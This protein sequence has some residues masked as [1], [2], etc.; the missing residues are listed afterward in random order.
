MAVILCSRFP[1]GFLALCW[2][3]Q[4]DRQTYVLSLTNSDRKIPVPA[5]LLNQGRRNPSLPVCD[6]VQEDPGVWLCLFWDHCQACRLTSLESISNK[7][8]AAKGSF[9]NKAVKT[10][11]QSP[12]V[13]EIEQ[14]ILAASLEWRHLFPIQMLSIHGPQLP[15]N[16]L[17]LHGW[18]VG[19]TGGELPLSHGVYI[20]VG[21]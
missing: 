1:L 10:V 15:I 19:R 17:A 5:S 20:R 2:D 6:S 7:A 4:K 8:K 18:I 21:F 3:P 9:P 11:S 16:R 12:R 13:L 14:H